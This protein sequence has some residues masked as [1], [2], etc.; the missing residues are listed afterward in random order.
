MEAIIIVQNP[1]IQHSLKEIGQSVTQR[2][3]DLN[4]DGQVATEETMQALKNLRAELNKEFADYETQR[5]AVK[6]A[7]LTPYEELEATYKVEISEKYKKAIDTLKDKI[8][9]VE[10]K[11]KANKLE[12]V[13]SYFVEL[14]MAEEI[15][16][17]S[18]PQTGIKIDLSTSMKK[19][20]EQVDE[21]VGRVKSDL[22]LIET[23][24]YK[25]EIMV[26]Y[27]NTLNVSQAITTITS[28]K[29]AEKAE[30]IRIKAQETAR[31]VAQLQNL[32]FVYHDIT[33]TYNFIQDE[34]LMISLNDIEN[35]PKD[36]FN[37]RLLEL[38]A[39]VA[40][41][42]TAKPLKAPVEVKPQATPEQTPAATPTQQVAAE[43][44]AA[45]APE[46][47]TATFEATGTYDQLN[48]LG[49][50]MKQN[51]ITYKNI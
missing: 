24:E 11:I 2:L 27:R 18:F 41:Y 46:L 48:G 51:G 29:E 33:R 34:S 15:D 20:R 7:V 37:A 28:R 39:K 36:E 14:V 44:Q 38:S 21:F 25:A 40:E 42:R 32:T 49:E 5:K 30:R 10:D 43:P 13:K 50:Y 23:Q 47:F 12:E 4:I 31:R 16:F 1:I 45:P 19:F 26:E 8:A 9:E 6:S 22:A 35:L 3:A 17:L